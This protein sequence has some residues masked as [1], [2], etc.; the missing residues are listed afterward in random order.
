MG[1]TSP[2]ALFSRPFVEVIGLAIEKGHV[3]VRRIASL[4]DLSVE[5]LAELFAAH[6]IACPFDL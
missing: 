5:A 4:L 3:S 2:P 1:S 6:R